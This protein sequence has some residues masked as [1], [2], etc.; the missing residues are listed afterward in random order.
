MVSAV[1]SFAMLS[2]LASGCQ[3][4]SAR[5]TVGLIHDPEGYGSPATRDNRFGH[6]A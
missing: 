4:L 5:S 6:E 2:H 1:G 3:D